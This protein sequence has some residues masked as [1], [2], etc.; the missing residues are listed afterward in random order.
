MKDDSLS[1]FRCWVDNLDPQKY[2]ASKMISL[3]NERKVYQHFI[4]YLNTLHLSLEAREE[5]QIQYNELK[6]SLKDL[7]GEKRTSNYRKSMAL[8]FWL[9]EQTLIDKLL[10]RYQFIVDELSKQLESTK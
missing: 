3:E 8:M 9:E 5:I 10:D 6:D 2:D 4:Q 7:E 1:K